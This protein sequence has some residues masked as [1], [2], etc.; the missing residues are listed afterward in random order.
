M[1][2]RKQWITEKLAKMS[3]TLLIELL[4]EE[5]PPSALLNLSSGLQNEMMQSLKKF[6]LLEENARCYSF[7][8]PRRLALQIKK[9]RSQAPQKTIIK[10]LVPTSVGFDE[11]GNPTKSLLKKMESIG[12]KEN[13]LKNIYS[14]KSGKVEMLFIRQNDLGVCLEKAI[15]RAL[16]RAVRKMPIPKLM[17]YQ[18]DDGVTDIKFVRPV[19][20][21]LAMYG[22][23][24][25]N[26]T[27]L[28]VE[29]S[30]HTKG[31]RFLTNNNVTLDHADDYEETLFNLGKVIVSSAKRKASIRRQ[32]QEHAERL[33]YKLSD[34][35]PSNLI[36]EVTALVEWPVIYNASFNSEFLTL[37]AECLILTMTTHQKFFPLFDNND[38]L[39]NRFLVVSNMDLDNP[40]NIIEG[41]KRVITPRLQDA[42]FFFETDCR[43]KLNK[44]LNLLKNMVFHNKLGSLLDRTNRISFLSQHIA[45][46]IG[47]STEE[48]H[49]A[50][51]LC[52]TDLTTEMVGEFP[53]LQGTMG[54]YYA[55]K[56]KETKNVAEAIEDHYLPRFQSDLIPKTKIGM[57]VALADKVDLI[58]AIFS[59]NLIPTGDKDPYGLRRCGIGIV[60]ILIENKISID[61]RRLLHKG[62]EKIVIKSPRENVPNQVY[63]FILERLKG[64]L[65]DKGFS[66]DE[67]E[68]VAEKQ[69]ISFEN[70]LSLLY[71]IRNFKLLKEAGN[72]TAANKR[73]KNILR[74]NSFVTRK[75]IFSQ[76]E[77]KSE[78]ELNNKI[79]ELSPK[80]EDFLKTSKFE[81]ALKLLS[82]IA[83]HV[84]NFFNDVLVIDKD[85]NKK[86][87]RLALLNSLELLLNRVANIAVLNLTPKS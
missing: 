18:L 72:L 22:R 10:K 16:D 8:T 47:C 56:D 70:I 25:V 45:D 85:E 46:L 67:I 53:E 42:R 4:T 76:L 82:S 5:L 30:N 84:D 27:V 19:R 77:H 12:V 71:A 78:I 58:L 28:G 2:F 87:N 86:N 39:T 24:T 15:D 35:S 43:I 31:H 13:Q 59:I 51:Q 52:K 23:K 21:L 36:D 68:A 55:L 64:Y 29:S 49:R 74:K 14:D 38:K 81:E 57:C 75:I 1:N 7:E 66:P 61:L 34:N 83:P 20:G 44:R 80:I 54:K 60:R 3:D 62:I 17:T 32:C 73:I 79:Q 6:E 50:G 69:I 48:A 9:V 40:T 41:N 65:K 11:E 26:A 33:G 63:D 37:P